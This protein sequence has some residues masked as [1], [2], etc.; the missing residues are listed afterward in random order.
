MGG[1][2]KI[3]FLPIRI[4]RNFPNLTVYDA[5]ACS[6][7]TISKEPFRN[8]WPLKQLNLNQNN[9]ANIPI[10]SFDDLANLDTL[11]IGTK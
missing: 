5:H 1:N 2:K 6:I 4:D 7:S 9:I 3:F 8:A 11:T 10:N